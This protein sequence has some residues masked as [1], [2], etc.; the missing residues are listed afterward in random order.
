[1]RVRANNASGGGGSQYP[2][3]EDATN[4]FQGQ[5]DYRVDCGFQ[6]TYVI[7]TGTASS[8]GNFIRGYYNGNKYEAWNGVAWRSSTFSLT[9]DS[10]GCTIKFTDGGW[11]SF[12]ECLIV[13]A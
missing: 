3:V 1:M 8:V 2:Y 13:C 5:Q 10:N 6:P 11:T 4:T 9:T 7:I 12:T